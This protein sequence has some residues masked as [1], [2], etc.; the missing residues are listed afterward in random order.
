MSSLQHTFCIYALSWA[1][2]GTCPAFCHSSPCSTFTRSLI[3]YKRLSS[4]LLLGSFSVCWS[5]LAFFMGCSPFE[6]LYTRYII[7][8]LVFRFTLSYSCFSFLD[9]LAS[10]VL[11]A[12]SFSNLLLKLYIT[13]HF[14]SWL[15]SCGDTS[16]YPLA[17][18][19]WVCFSCQG[20]R[21]FSLKCVN[22]AIVE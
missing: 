19:R 6:W 12:L 18:F 2:A 5:A 20:L 1:L 7:G 10:W 16:K 13:Y 3:L 22:K 14:I 15:V 4:F 9:I 11:V 17:S 8:L 21:A